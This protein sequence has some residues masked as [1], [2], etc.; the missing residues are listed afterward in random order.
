MVS[1]TGPMNTKC[2]TAKAE[3]LSAHGIDGR[4]RQAFQLAN[5]GAELVDDILQVLQDSLPARISPLSHKYT[6][7]FVPHVRAL[8]ALKDVSELELF[9]QRI[10][11][12]QISLIRLLR[13]NGRRDA[14][15]F[16]LRFCHGDD[17]AL[18]RRKD[19]DVLEVHSA[20]ARRCCARIRC[21]GRSS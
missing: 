15:L 12:L 3:E 6:T 7:P 16:G 14:P 21:A 18:L 2:I 17:W 5:V 13:R 1:L 4:L 11:Q 10:I 19:V 9:D 20:L 8:G